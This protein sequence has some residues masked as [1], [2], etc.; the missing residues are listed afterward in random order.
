MQTINAALGDLH[1]DDKTLDAV[2]DMWWPKLEQQVKDIVENHTD[3]GE[4]PVSTDRDMLLEILE[5]TRLTSRRAT[6][7]ASIH[8]QAVSELLAG[9]VAAHDALQSGKPQDAMAQLQT[10]KRALVYVA[11]RARPDARPEL[12]KLMKAV[13]DL[14]FTI[15]NEVDEIP[16]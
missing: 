13:D 15:G 7:S 8:P 9:Y 1:L 4:A 16:F 11:R 2:F 14:S 10:M 6:P 12:G 3:E 5:L